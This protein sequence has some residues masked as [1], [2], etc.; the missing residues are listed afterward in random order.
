MRW[1][2]EMGR[3]EEEGGRKE[4]RTKRELRRRVGEKEKKPE[5]MERGGEQGCAISGDANMIS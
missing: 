2:N 3:G 5:R 1:P 4:L